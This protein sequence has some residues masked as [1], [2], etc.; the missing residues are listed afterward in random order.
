MLFI[1]KNSENIFVTTL[2]E[3]TTF[4]PYYY[5]F[6]LICDDDLSETI[7]MGTD[8]STN[9]VR[10]NKYTIIETGS[11]SVNL[12]ASTIHLPTP[13]YYKYEIYQMHSAVISLSNVIGGPIEYGKAYVSGA[14]G[15]NDQVKYIYTGSTNL[16]V[17]N[18]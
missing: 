3:K 11:T 7:F 9:P 8:L 12:S 16:Y 2:A 4:S 6:R 1:N 15:V 18:N 10:Y 13:G 14:T 17:Y 5:L